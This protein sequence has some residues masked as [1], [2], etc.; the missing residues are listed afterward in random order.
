VTQDIG[1]FIERKKPDPK[2][3]EAHLELVDIR[4]EGSGFLATSLPII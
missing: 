3:A 2:K 1:A 4:D